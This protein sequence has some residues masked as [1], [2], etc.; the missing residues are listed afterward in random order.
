MASCGPCPCVSGKKTLGGA[1]VEAMEN[2]VVVANFFADMARECRKKLISAGY[3]D[4]TSAE[5]EDIVR[6]YLN[7]RRR[8]VSIRRRAVHRAAYSAPPNLVEGE[9]KFLAKAE[10]GDDLLPHQ[11]TR[12]EQPDYEDGM[13]NDFGIQHFHLGTTQ[14]PTR[15]NFV[16]RTNPLLFAMVQEDDLYCIGYY[17]HGEWSRATLLDVI[18]ENWPDTIA[19][20]SV[21]GVKLAHSYTDDEHEKLRRADINVATQRPDGTIHM[22]P[23]G[24]ITLAGTSIRDMRDL[25]SARQICSELESAVVVE[26]RKLV[27]EGKLAAPVRLELRFVDRGAYI[28]VDGG[29]VTYDVS[30]HITV[31]VL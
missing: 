18:H 23:G 11:S 9:K 3:S 19:G 27:D 29:E 6:A 28:D 1:K 15:P 14:H 7:V 10:A 5:D 22:G 16:A 21:D 20:Y 31:P 30:E 12:L 2:E 26:V 13:L 24:G 8:R 4:P 25:M 17:G